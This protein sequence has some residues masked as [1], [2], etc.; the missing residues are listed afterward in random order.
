VPS[1]AQLPSG[2][3]FRTRCP[4]A[5]ERCAVEDPALEAATGDHADDHRVACHRWD[6][7]DAMPVTVRMR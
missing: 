3:R 1:P 2:C 6:E 4:F 5:I 7:L